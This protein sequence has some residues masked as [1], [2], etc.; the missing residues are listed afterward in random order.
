M[1]NPN[2]LSKYLSQKVSPTRSV[3]IQI[4]ERK[5]I[6]DIL[7]YLKYIL[8]PDDQVSLK[9]IINVPNR[10]IGT[11]TIAKLEDYASTHDMTLHQVLMSV[12]EL[13]LGL[14][15]ASIKSIKDFAILIRSLHSHIDQLNPMTLIKRIVSDTRYETYLIHSEGKTE[16]E[17]K[18]K[19]SDN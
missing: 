17:E 5:E 11:T 8:N 6:K 4:F 7:A 9:R 19:T 14:G 15:S 16:A 3:M 2:L 18:C 1:H 12:S 10:K 13:P